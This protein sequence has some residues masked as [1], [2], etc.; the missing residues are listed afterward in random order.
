MSTEHTGIVT[1][2]NITSANITSANIGHAHPE[3]PETSVKTYAAV[4]AGLLL[5]TFITVGASYINFGSGTVNIVIALGI[6]TVK[7]TLVALFFMHLIH[8]KPINAV[9]ISAGFV[10]LGLLLLFT[11][12]DVKS[13]IVYKAPPIEKAAPASATTG[14]PADAAHH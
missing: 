2:A 6:A 7:A 4:L 3:H 10:F 11:L 13:R 9:V 1:P 14:M 12:T 5:L 8:D